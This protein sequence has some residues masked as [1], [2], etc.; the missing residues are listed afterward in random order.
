MGLNYGALFTAWGVGGVV[1][2]MLA[3]KIAD[4]TGSYTGAYNI[5]GMLLMLAFVL[6]MLSY[7]EVS[8]S[9]EQRAL[10]IKL[11]GNKRAAA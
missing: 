3:G 1:G 4:A 2:P 6:A 9:L 8:V 10:T 5:A 7:I 11:G